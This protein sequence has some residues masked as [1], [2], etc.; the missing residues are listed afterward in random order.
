[1]LSIARKDEKG[2]IS[3]KDVVNLVEARFCG[4]R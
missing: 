2:Q 3:N 4:G 1:M